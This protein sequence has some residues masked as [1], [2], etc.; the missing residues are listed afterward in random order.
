MKK[1]FMVRNLVIN[2]L[3]SLVA[4]FILVSLFWLAGGSN[5]ISFHETALNQA[6]GLGLWAMILS[7][8][9]GIYGYMVAFA[10]FMVFMSLSG[11][12]SFQDEEFDLE[13]DEGDGEKGIVKWFNV[14]KGFG[15][16][17][18]EGGDDVF[19]HFRSIRGRG[20]RSL[21]EGQQVRFT[22]IESDKGLQAENVSIVR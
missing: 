11:F 12:L 20:H 15:F 21:S 17:T 22:V 18:R 16:I 4:P 1:N 3:I 6:G 8:P 13:M 19:V 5:L 14:S 9:A 10:V 7:K 2:L